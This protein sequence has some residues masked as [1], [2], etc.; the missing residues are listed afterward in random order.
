MELKDTVN[1]M[2]SHNYV[3]RFK[4]EY[5][6]IS[7]RI[8]KLNIILENYKAGTLK[9]VPQCSYEVL[10]EQLVHMKAYKRMLDLRADIEGIVP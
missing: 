5:N 1:D 6:Q 7:I 2:L 4:A 9:F 10:Y 8:Y 3:D